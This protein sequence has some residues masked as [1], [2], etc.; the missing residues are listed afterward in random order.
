MNQAQRGT[1]AVEPVGQDPA[2]GGKVLPVLHGIFGRGRNWSSLA[3]ALAAR[4]PDWTPLLVDLRLHGDSTAFE[5]PHTIQA[6]A[7]DV[8]DTLDRPIDAVLG[9]SF[10]GKVALALA[11]DLERARQVWIVESSPDARQPGGSAWQLLQTVTALPASFA[12]RGELVERLRAGHVDQRTAQWM[13]SNLESVSGDV[14]RWRLDLDA[15][16]ELLED[17]FRRDLW[18][19]VETP[20]GD[21]HLH[22]VKAEDSTTIDEEACRRILAAGQRHGRASLHRVAGGHWVNADDPDALL[23]LLVEHLP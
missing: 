5:P 15:V 13:A 9:H 12:S 3:R 8:I 21:V 7:R 17:F 4:R 22:F 19:L 16:Q 18:S 11:G 1:L 6:A 20:P 14:Y 10:G 2:A 23:G